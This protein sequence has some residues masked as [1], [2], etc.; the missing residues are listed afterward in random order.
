MQK[1]VQRLWIYDP[2][3][4]EK[5]RMSDLWLDHVTVSSL[6]LTD[7]V[8]FQFYFIQFYINSES[9]YTVFTCATRTI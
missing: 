6:L 5:H 8:V 1:S 9:L 2:P 3:S 7:T 4:S